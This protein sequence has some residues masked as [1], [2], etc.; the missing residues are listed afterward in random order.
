MKTKMILDI[1]K[2]GLNLKNAREEAGI[3][4]A[5]FVKEIFRYIWSWLDYC[6]NIKM[7]D[8]KSINGLG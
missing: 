2:L 8:W 4:Q 7:G 6:H 1:K 5:N 3:S